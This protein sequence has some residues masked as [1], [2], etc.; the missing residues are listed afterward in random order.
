MTLTT[1]FECGSGKL[2]QIGEDHW[3]IDTVADRFGYN[4]YFCFEVANPAGSQA[5]ELK[6]DIFADPTLGAASH[7]LGHFPSNIWY[8][9]R[10]WRRWIP[11]RNTWEDAVRFLPDRISLKIP[12]GPGAK[13][14]VATN[15]PFRY[16]DYMEWVESLRPAGGGLLQIS[17]LGRSFENRDIPVLSIGDGRVKM[18]VLAG[19]HASEHSGIWAAKCIVDFL[20]SANPEAAR[21]QQGFTFCLVPMLNPDGNVH[22]R[23][24]AGI[25]QFD[26]NNSAD[27]VGAPEGKA[28]L[29]TENR[30]LWSLLQEQKPEVFLHFHGYLGWRAFGDL[31]GDGIYVNPPGLGLPD[32]S[33]HARHH[34]AILERVLFDTPGHTAHF[35]DLGENIEGMVDYQLAKA[36]GTATLLYEVNS[37]SV[38]VAE[39]YRRGLQVLRA[40]TSAVLDSRGGTGH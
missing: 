30:L 32:D 1:D 23:S 40:V 25:E 22:G 21:L 11:L 9:A 38:G 5:G 27:F 8:S 36:F 37:G 6:V 13:L 34:R 12:L 19:Q 29:Y 33:P 26:V 7:F 35:G 24:G 10:N 31:P 18:F 20:L 4:K 17:T 39:Q 28:P 3:E 2:R 14:Q 15:P 16:S